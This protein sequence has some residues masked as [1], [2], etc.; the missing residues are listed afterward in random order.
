LLEIVARLLAAEL[1]E[2]GLAALAGSEL[3]GAMDEL[4]PGAAAHIGDLA[5][6]GPAG[7]EQ[8]AGAYCAL[9]LVPG[10]ASPFASAWL[11][12]NPA[13]RGAT[14]TGAVANW[15]DQLGVSLASGVWGNLPRD[16]LA[17]LL[18][19]RALALT[20][21]P[22]YGP[23]L[24]EDIRARALGPWVGRFAAAVC[25]RTDSPL[26]RAVARLAAALAGA[27]NSVTR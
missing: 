9:F 2:P 25:A 23:A 24:A 21:P 19:L 15:M 1:D 22:P 27:D 6:R 10:G 20:V 5:A 12:G 26:Y 18:G 13:E 11:G 8:A 17:V 4:S 14:V 3:I 16:H 7:V